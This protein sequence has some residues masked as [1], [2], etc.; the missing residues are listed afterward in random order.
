[1][2]TGVSDGVVVSMYAFKANGCDGGRGSF[3]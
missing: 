2:M 1:M 3:Y